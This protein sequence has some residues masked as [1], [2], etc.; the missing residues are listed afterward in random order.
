M[1]DEMPVAVMT[2][3][4]NDFT[5]NYMNKASLEA[6]RT[7]EHV[8]PVPADKIQ[9]QCIDIFHKAPSH[10]RE[11]LRDPKNLPHKAKFSIGGEWLDLLATAV[12]DARGNYVCP[13]ISWR[14][15]T[16][17]VQQEVEAAK[18]MQMLDQMPINVMLADKDSWKLSYINQTSLKT[19]KSIE[20]LLPVKADE[21]Q[22][23]CIDIFHK[24]PEH[25]RKMLA[26]PSNLPH[27]AL[28]KLGDET[29]KLDVSAINDINGN[30]IAAMVSWDVVTQNVKMAHNVSHV[31]EAVSSAATE[32]QASAQSMTSTAE[33]TSSISATV[34]S[35]AEELSS[36]ISEISRQVSQST[37]IANGAVA[38]AGRSS[39]M[40]NRLAEAAQKI[41]DVVDLI[42]NIASQTNLLALNATIEAARAGEAGKGFAVVASEVKSLANQ[43]A[44]AT[45]EISQQISEIQSA[46]QDAVGANET[47]GKTI[48]QVSEIATAIAAAVEEQGAAT[49]EVSSNI[50]QVSSASGET[51]QLAADVSA[52][53]TELSQQAESLRQSVQDFLKEIGAA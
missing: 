7:I 21:I 13:M 27:Q 17:E 26:D 30:Y 6:L 1:V 16:K 24:H 12:V 50:V 40:I 35:A 49:Q 14:V 31:V 8:L 42:Q 38:E 9:G 23:Q 37:E 39:E 32:M 44:S 28:I 34:A 41:G 29:L 46:T 45:E 10:Q 47:I 19:L 20:H 53:S 36:S 25:Q 5:I 48:Q 2:C 51:G 4:L 22:G 43:T 15:V 3:D 11:L 33:E 52:A 18:L